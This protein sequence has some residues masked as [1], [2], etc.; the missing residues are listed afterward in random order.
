M[1]NH[2][3]EAAPST[4]ALEWE[5][6]G[7]DGEDQTQDTAE[8]PSV[9]Q[10]IPE[11]KTENKP[12]TADMVS[13]KTEEDMENRETTPLIAEDEKEAVEEI[14]RSDAGEAAEKRDIVIAPRRIRNTDGKTSGPHQ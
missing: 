3:A 4:Q 12:E 5:A 1:W 6:E 14:R 11:E 10:E 9:N 13:V 7:E 8:V 2:P